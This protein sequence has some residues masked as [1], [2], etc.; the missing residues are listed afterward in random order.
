[1]GINGSSGPLDADD[2]E[3]RVPDLT[4]A[5][6]AFATPRVYVARTPRDFVMIRRGESVSPTPSREF[7]RTERLV[8]K[9]DAYAPGG[10]AITV[11]A[12]LLN[13]QGDKLVDVPV[14]SRVP[15][16][17]YWPGSR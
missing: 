17:S 14:T 5:E 1:M 12:Q 9:L 7:R 13:R 2:R 10:A 16:F 3:V 11:S 4:S 6:V 8:A 15:A